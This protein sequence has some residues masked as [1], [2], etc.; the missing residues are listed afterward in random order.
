MAPQLHDKDEMTEIGGSF[1]SFLKYKPEFDHYVTLGSSMKCVVSSR[2]LFSL[3]S[4]SPLV[5]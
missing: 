5:S 3:N 2:L 1:P 4:I